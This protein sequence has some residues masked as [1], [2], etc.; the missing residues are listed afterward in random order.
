MRQRKV[1]TAFHWISTFGNVTLHYCTLAH[2]EN[3]HGLS[4]IATGPRNTPRPPRSANPDT[5]ATGKPPSV[6][7]RQR[8]RAAGSKLEVMTFA[9]R[10]RGLDASRFLTKAR[11]SRSLTSC[12]ASK[13]AL[14]GSVTSRALR[15][16]ARCLNSASAGSGGP[17][18][19]ARG[20]T[21]ATEESSGSARVS[22]AAQEKPAHPERSWQGSRRQA[23]WP[24]SFSLVSWLLTGV[25]ES[26][27]ANAEDMYPGLTEPS[28]YVD[29][30]ELTQNSH[31]RRQVTAEH[32]GEAGPRHAVQPF[33]FES[34]P[35]PED[36]PGPRPCRSTRI[37]SAI[38]KL[39]SRMRHARQTRLAIA[40]LQALDD[41]T[42]KDI[43]IR[44]CQ[45]E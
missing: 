6:M 26:F 12:S 5:A 34:R 39:R 9:M 10:V 1:R 24:A 15:G 13:A 7:R 14:R 30:Q 42:L 23:S 28:D 21:K 44:L 35:S 22:P 32:E 18:L 36:A 25:V 43:G 27:A 29:R 31:P 4:V 17:T 2:A 19:T 11:M 8:H 33:S 38:A 45:I 37:I 20:G 41:R 3:I 40:R 16:A